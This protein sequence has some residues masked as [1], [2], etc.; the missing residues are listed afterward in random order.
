MKNYFTIFALIL[1]SLLSSCKKDKN[2]QP[3]PIV[4]D[5]SLVKN[6]EISDSSGI[7]KSLITHLYDGNNRL[8]NMTESIYLFPSGFTLFNYTIEYLASKV[9]LKR[10]VSTKSQWYEKTVYDI[11]IS[12]LATSSVD[13]SIY[14]PTDSTIHYSSTYQYNSDGYLIKRIDIAPGGIPVTTTF[15]YSNFNVESL[16]IS[17]ESSS[18]GFTEQYSYSLDHSNTI[19]N[20][21][22]GIEFLG[23][24]SSNPLLQAILV[25]E[26]IE[27]SNY[28]YI[29]DSNNRIIKITISG[30]SFG[31][32][33]NWICMPIAMP[34]EVLTYTYY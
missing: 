33:I 23:K 6:I 16:T 13:L 12:G 20:H 4:V 7:V 17:S 21:N 18:T 2:D 5:S 32:G 15:Q 25:P 28:S 27:R 31:A 14:S 30:N 1:V 34:T 22:L 11:G 29:Y 26:Q 9:I 10:T 19:S 8:I 3:T 24:S